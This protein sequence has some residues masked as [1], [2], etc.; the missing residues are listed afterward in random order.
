M[1][2]S[3]KKN[4]R[5]RARRSELAKSGALPGSTPVTERARDQAVCIRIRSADLAYDVFDEPLG[6]NWPRAVY[7]LYIRSHRCLGRS[8]WR[9]A[10]RL[11]RIALRTCPDDPKLRNNLA[12]AL[13]GQGRKDEA[14]TLVRQ[15]C[16]E[17]PDY[18][19]PRTG[20]AKHCIKE[21]RLD[22]ARAL[23]QPVRDMVCLHVCE[24]S[25]LCVSE[26][27]LCI[28][29][30]RWP[31]AANW[32]DLLEKADS[33]HPMLESVTAGIVR[34][35]ANLER[36]KAKRAARAQRKAAATPKAPTVSVRDL[37]QLTMPF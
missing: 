27:E 12:M 35:G 7:N 34:L 5:I 28:A 22:E 25:A 11:L 21:G 8:S 23:L 4:Q 3:G 6:H 32:L 16:D 15:V 30:E 18:V 31:E 29:E 37:S 1:I 33:D 17:C 24:L 9:E 19:F 20:L 13:D 2:K 26:I 10:E 36:D 14:I